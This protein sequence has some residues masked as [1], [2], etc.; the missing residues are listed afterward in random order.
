MFENVITLINL[1]SNR[2]III[3]VPALRIQL[4]KIAITKYKNWLSFVYNYKLKFG[5]IFGFLQCFLIC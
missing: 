3:L 1:E 2:N 5:F 4:V